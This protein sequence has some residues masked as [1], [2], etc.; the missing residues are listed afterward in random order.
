MKCHVPGRVHQRLL[1]F[2][3]QLHL[4]VAD[5]SPVAPTVQELHD[6]LPYLAPLLPIVIWYQDFAQTRAGSIR[7]NESQFAL[8]YGAACS[9]PGTSGRRF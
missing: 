1:R 6:L 4:P 9:L 2:L 3:V 7:Q 5:D 8:S